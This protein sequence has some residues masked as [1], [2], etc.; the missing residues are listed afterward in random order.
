MVSVTQDDIDSG[1]RN[2]CTNCPVARAMS[3]ELGKDITIPSR[4]AWFD[5]ERK[6]LPFI[7]STFIARFDNSLPVEPFT[8]EVQL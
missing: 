2:S 4:W 8:F 7:V 1:Y 6:A 3:R 5:G